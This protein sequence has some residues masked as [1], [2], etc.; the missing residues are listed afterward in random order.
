MLSWSNAARITLLP[1]HNAHPSN[2]A[3]RMITKNHHRAHVDP[4]FKYLKI[5][6][7]MAI[8]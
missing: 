2:K 7:F 6:Q 3:L 4:L 8:N 5:Q 1:L